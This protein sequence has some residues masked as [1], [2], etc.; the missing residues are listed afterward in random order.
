M[1]EK[2]RE[3]KSMKFRRMAGELYVERR[4]EK[5]PEK[6][7]DLLNTAHNAVCKAFLALEESLTEAGE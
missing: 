2:E 4:N 3:R 1:T 5:L 7:R 6:V